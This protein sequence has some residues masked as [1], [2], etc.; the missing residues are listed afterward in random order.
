MLQNDLTV[1]T[2]VA[3]FAN[4]MK[5]LSIYTGKNITTLM[6][7]FLLYGTLTAQSAYGLCLP[8]WTHSIFP[9]GELLDAFLLQLDLLSYGP[10]NRLNGG[11]FESQTN[12]VYNVIS[13]L[14]K[15]FLYFIYFKYVRNI[16]AVINNGIAKHIT[17]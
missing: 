9:N 8:E 11:M 5:Q 7:I 15:L 10:L 4:L 6:D 3:K 2:K 13:F 14:K 1:K 12:F 16:L 17:V